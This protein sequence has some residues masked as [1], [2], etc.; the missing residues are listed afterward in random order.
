MALLLTALWVEC[1]NIPCPS[2]ATWE[3]SVLLLQHLVDGGGIADAGKGYTTEAGVWGQ[4]AEEWAIVD[5]SV[6]GSDG[7]VGSVGCIDES[8]GGVGLGSSSCIGRSGSVVVVGCG[9]GRCLTFSLLFGIGCE[10]GIGLNEIVVNLV[11]LIGLPELKIGRALKQFLHTLRLLD[12]WQ[13]DEDTASLL[14]L[15]NVGRNDAETV[16]TVAEDVE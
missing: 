4:L 14:Q 2:E 1:L 10:T 11:G 16:D 6:L 13:L 8:V 15:L 7:R 9:I 12:T 3:T 5:G